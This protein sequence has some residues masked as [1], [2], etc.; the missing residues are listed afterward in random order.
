MSPDD[1]FACAIVGSLFFFSGSTLFFLA[2]D[3]L[4]STGFVVVVVASQLCKLELEL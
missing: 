1:A 3:W 2:R 4:G